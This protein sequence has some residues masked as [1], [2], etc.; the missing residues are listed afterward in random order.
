MSL[1]CCVALPVWWA[2][3][4]SAR[5]PAAWGGRRWSPGATAQPG[6]TPWRLSRI[7]F[8]YNIW[9]THNNVSTISRNSQH[10]FRCT[11]PR[12][13]SFSSVSVQVP[14]VRLAAQNGSWKHISGRICK[15]DSVY[16]LA[17]YVFVCK[18]VWNTE[19]RGQVVTTPVSYSEGLKF[20]SRLQDRLSWLRP[21][22][23]L[24]QSLWASTAVV[25]TSNL[26]K[27]IFSTQYSLI[28]PSLN[29]IFFYIH[30]FINNQN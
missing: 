15:E 4:S 5:R 27:P 24:P 11:A 29:A 16:T 12:G 26:T 22:M 21:F 2:R 17:I 10:H 8:I 20:K 7:I 9:H 14:S 19:L 30:I 25:R 6:C 28:E 3:A 23:V 1:Y 18:Y 13:A